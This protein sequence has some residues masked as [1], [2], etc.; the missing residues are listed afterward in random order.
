MKITISDRV[1]IGFFADVILPSFP[2][3][4]FRCSHASYE[5][6]ILNETD[7]ITPADRGI[8]MGMSMLCVIIIRITL[9][10]RFVC[11]KYHNDT[12]KIRSVR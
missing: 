5:R 1:S 2:S 12:N 3:V 8:V 9:T 11:I 4:V 7:V 10:W 6:Q